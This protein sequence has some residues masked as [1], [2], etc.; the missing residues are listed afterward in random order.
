M[1]DRQGIGFGVE[2]QC[3][4]SRHV[5]GP[6][7]GSWRLAVIFLLDDPLQKNRSAGRRVLLEFVM[8]LFDK[9]IVRR[10]MAKYFGCVS[11]DLKH[12]M[13]AYAEIR[14]VDQSCA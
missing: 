2:P 13:Y 6:C 10:K 7:A 12:Q 4:P 1:C 3:M 9:R 5:P 11:G 14:P 8:G